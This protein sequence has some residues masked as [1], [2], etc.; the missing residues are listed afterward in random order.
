MFAIGEQRGT[1]LEARCDRLLEAQFSAE[2]E[3]LSDPETGL[4]RAAE[5]KHCVRQDGKAHGNPTL[6]TSFAE[7]LSCLLGEL[8]RLFIV[9]PQKRYVADVADG[10]CSVMSSSARGSDGFVKELDCTIELF[11]GKRRLSELMERT[12]DASEISQLSR[13]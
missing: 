3:A 7:Q 4:L 9:A 2:F 10:A 1:G 5:Q 11:L 13:Q 8:P 12:P 6:M